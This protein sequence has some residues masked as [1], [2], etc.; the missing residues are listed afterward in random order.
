MS[1]DRMLRLLHIS[2][3]HGR[4][5]REKEPWR[6][7]RVLG[8]AWDSNLAQLIQDGP[9]DLVCFTG[10]A[11]D[12]GLPE[13]YPELTDFFEALLDRLR[14]PRER[15]FLVP[16]NHDIDRG[17]AS[18]IWPKFRDTPVDSLSFS[19]W[20]AG[21]E[22]APP[23]FEP[24]W[25]EAILERA[26]AWRRWVQRDL[27]RPELEPARSAHGTL[28]FR[29]TLDFHGLPVHMIGLDTAWLSGD[30]ADSGRL[31]LTE[32][33]LQALVHDEKG[34]PL[35][36]LRLALMHHP[37]SELADGA[38][39]RRLVDG[40]L[41]LVLRGH[42]HD[43]E[44]ETWIDPGRK[45]R[46][47]AAGC[48]YEGHDADRYHNACQVI[49]LHLDG[50][51]KPRRVALRFRGFSPR[52][53]HWFDDDSLYK[54]S[55]GGRLAWQIATPVQPAAGENPYD[56]WTPVTPP[57]FVGRED[58]LRRLE[59]ALEEKRSVS[60]VGDWRVGKTSLLETWR[61][62]QA[63]RGREVRLLSGEGSEGE[64]LAG[65]VSAITGF[66]AE[67][68][69]DRA[70]DALAAWAQRSPPDLPPL[71][72]VDEFDG[73][74]PRIEHRFFERLRAML[75]RI[76][77]VFSTRRE[78]DLIYSD[79]ERTSP[80]YNR[81][82]ILW[83]GLLEAEPAGELIRWGEESFAPGD[84]GLVARQAG[85]HPFYLQLLG[86]H[87][88]AAR[89][90]GGAPERALDRFYAEANARLR[91]LWRSLE[92]R[93]RDR[94][95]ATNTGRECRHR[96]LRARGLVTSGGRPF[97]QVLAVFLREET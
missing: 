14:L 80:F 68:E 75:G 17:A 36:G 78:L 12:R 66:A 10:D 30:D 24:T 34:E 50:R 7:R 54:D 63:G 86:R 52:G 67:D 11:A 8:P 56:P 18:E 35:A 15:L 42:L 45:V 74:V 96:V 2:D 31:R 69:P 77:F 55:R 73:M 37:F 26:A 82:E 53:G 49:T 58:E 60:L 38:S 95:L 43:P 21:L 72:L 79:L 44:V 9:I 57:R 20:M 91:E 83:L 41:D 70:A 97:G 13:E 94:L 6:R 39:C 87:M 61:R 3:I 46:Q 84:A 93:D 76:L 85:R 89:R 88:V 23:G 4:G 81:L 1:T 40:S 71:V 5:S 59:A 62:R 32:N 47:L 64:S 28:G 51:G 33:Q 65:F 25:R 27:K 92:Q 16:G 19:R 22:A 29:V 48:L 90:Q